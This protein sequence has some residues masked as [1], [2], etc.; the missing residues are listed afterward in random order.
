M[1]AAKFFL[2]REVDEVD[3]KPWASLLP[4]SAKP[5]RTNLFGDTFLLDGAG[6]VHMLERAG[7]S[8]QQVAPSEETF[9]HELSEDPEGWL[10]GS[11]VEECR[12]AD[13]TLAT[14]QCYAFS[15]PPILGGDY[16]AENIW[17]APWRDWFAFTEQIFQKIKDLPD[18]T[19]VTIEIED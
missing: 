9:W 10:L 17:V 12:G 18:G 14:G 2:P 5:L 16:S 19:A 3:L 1:D 7:C 4:T 15:T 11:L 6:A 13:K 8:C